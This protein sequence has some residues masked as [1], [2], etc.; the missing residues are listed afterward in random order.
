MKCKIVSF[1]DVAVSNKLK[2]IRNANVLVRIHKLVNWGRL[3]TIL[4]SVDF[5]NSSH[6]GRDNYDP[7]IMFKILFLQSLHNFSDREIEEHL[8]FNL[9]FMQFCGF[10]IDSTIPDHSTIARWRDRFVEK[11]V[12]FESF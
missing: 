12:Y 9:L 1:G 6:F 7:L 10:S 5:R 2:R 11:D 8:N 3:K 4:S